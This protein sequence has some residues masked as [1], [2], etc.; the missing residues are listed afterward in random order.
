MLLLKPLFLPCPHSVFNLLVDLFPFFL[1]VLGEEMT[2]DH[3]QGH[4][5]PGSRG[6]WV[7]SKSS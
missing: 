2:G 5:F 6:A 3:D 7:A 1:P 4:L